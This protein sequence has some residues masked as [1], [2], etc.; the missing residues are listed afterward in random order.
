MAST[1]NRIHLVCRESTRHGY[2]QRGNVFTTTAWRVSEAAARSVREIY[3]HDS[4]RSDSWVQGQ[5]VG[6]PRA[7]QYP[8]G[9]RWEWDVQIGGAA[10]SWP[11]GAS[12]GGPEKAYV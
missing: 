8:K 1:P 9:T 12:G 5:V 10:A 2:T 11:Q 7:V 4:K 3:L 6:E